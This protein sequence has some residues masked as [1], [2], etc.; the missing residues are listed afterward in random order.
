MNIN[1]QGKTNFRIVMVGTGATGSQLLPFLSQLLN[2]FTSTNSHELVLMDGDHFEE[3][4][5][6]NQKCTI[7]DVSRSKAQVLCERYQT[8]Y[9]DLDISFMDEY[10]LKSDRLVNLLKINPNAIPVLISCVDNN[11]SRKLFNE[12]FNDTRL[13]NLIYIDSGNGTEDRSGQVVVGYKCSK[14]EQDTRGNT[15]YYSSRYVSYKVLEPA[16]D[17]FKDIMLDNDTLESLTSCTQ[18]VDEH[19]QNIA[20]NVMAASTVFTILNELIAFKKINTHVAY[21]DAENST[22]DT[23]KVKFS[24]VEEAFTRDRR[25]EP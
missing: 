21:F 9:K 11:A 24:K 18:V 17:M 20:T 1:M 15:N 7:Y 5:L 12:V 6:K 14:S 16:C 2:N 23:K 13:K 8:V 19:P 10:A 4:N 22:V 3:K 25:M